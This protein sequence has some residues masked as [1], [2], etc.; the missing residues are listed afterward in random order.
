MVN[1]I[2]RWAKEHI[3]RGIIVIYKLLY[4]YI[5]PWLQPTHLPLS[6]KHKDTR[7]HFC[8]IYWLIMIP[9]RS[10]QLKNSRAVKNTLHWTDSPSMANQRFEILLCLFFYHSLFLTCF[11]WPSKLKCFRG[12]DNYWLVLANRRSSKDTHC[13]L[14]IF[15][16]YSTLLLSLFTDFFCKALYQRTCHSPIWMCHKILATSIIRHLL[17]LFERIKPCRMN[18]VKQHWFWNYIII[19]C[20]SKT[21]YVRTGHNVVEPADRGNFIIS[22]TSFISAT[23]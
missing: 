23:I 17:L 12:S 11:D 22:F 6:L 15:D 21:Y 13:L 19:L 16:L 18:K 14:I 5:P 1:I 8:L 20:S 10:C 9:S 3:S 2:Q 7:W 4:F